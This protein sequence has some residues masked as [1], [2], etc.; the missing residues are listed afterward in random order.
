M[1]G[2]VPIYRHDSARLVPSFL[3]YTAG[4]KAHGFKRAKETT[5][6]FEVGIWAAY[7]NIELCVGKSSTG[8][9]RGR[10]RQRNKH[11]IMATMLASDGREICKFAEVVVVAWR[12][13]I[14]RG[15]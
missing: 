10:L 9:C 12:G 1:T 6:T 15:V 4:V 11:L 8:Y 14:S 3:H 2:G 13:V 5:W 7:G